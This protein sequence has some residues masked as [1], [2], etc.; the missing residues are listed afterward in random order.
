MLVLVRHGETEA[1]AARLL[2][3]RAQSPLTERGVAQAKALSRLLGPVARVVSSPLAR[4]RDSAAALGL[5]V[6]VE[7][8]DRW[9]EVDYGEYDGQ[10][11]GS[12]PAEVWRRWRADPGFRP[13]GGESLADMG[14]RVRAAC[15]ELFAADGAGARGAADVVVVSHVSP[16]KAAVAWALGTG[17]ALAWRLYLSTA[18]MTVIGWGSDAP[19]L[20]AYNLTAEALDRR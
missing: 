11:L 10:P 4:A 14:A 15:D 19:V 5:D 1:N 20:H 8:D 12:V 2:L 3:G 16:I 9:I 7:I 13:A 17:D 6:P 18:S